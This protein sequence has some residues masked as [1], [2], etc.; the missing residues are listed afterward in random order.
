MEKSILLEQQNRTLYI[1]LT[2]IFFI[3]GVMLL[4]R[5]PL[6]PYQMVLGILVILL[7]IIIGIYSFL[8][9]SV[10]STYAAKIRITDQL[11]ELRPGFLKPLI[12]LNWQDVKNIKLGNFNIEFELTNGTKTISY[13][14]SAER[15]RQVQQ[16]LREIAEQRNIQVI[17]D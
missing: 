12:Q 10:N 8:G 11:I 5:E 9:F 6:P 13:S 14:T 16:L 15:S 3:N 4:I 1:L 7:S 17:I 2:V